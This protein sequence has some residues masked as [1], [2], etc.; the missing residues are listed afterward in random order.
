MLFCFALIQ[1]DQVMIQKTYVRVSLEQDGYS[2]PFFIL[3]F[4]GGPATVSMVW[5]P[6]LMFQEISLDLQAVDFETL[7]L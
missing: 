4:S 5:A 3:I 1:K 7:K 6:K 2:S